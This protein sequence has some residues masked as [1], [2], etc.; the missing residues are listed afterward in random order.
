MEDNY[1]E[2]W[3]NQLRICELSLAQLIRLYQWKE[4]G[5]VLDD[6]QEL[7]VGENSE[8]VNSLQRQK[9]KKKAEI[10]SIQQKIRTEKEREKRKRELNARNTKG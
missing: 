6:K 4:N 1:N 5:V 10:L 9:D 3:K 8:I 7:I 2:L